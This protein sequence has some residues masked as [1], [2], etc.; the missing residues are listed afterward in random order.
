MKIRTKQGKDKKQ[1]LNMQWA[2]LRDNMR[3]IGRSF[4]HVNVL[5][6]IQNS[7]WLSAD[8]QEHWI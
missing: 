1:Y 6:L 8:V 7:F 5:M 3:G 2:V 4:N